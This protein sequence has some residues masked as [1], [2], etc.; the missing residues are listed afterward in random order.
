MVEQPKDSQSE[1][2]QAQNSET[3]APV[4]DAQEKHARNPVVESTCCLTCLPQRPCF[5]AFLP[6]L[7]L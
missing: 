3:G 6:L 7:L 2:L 5:Q 4:S 1:E